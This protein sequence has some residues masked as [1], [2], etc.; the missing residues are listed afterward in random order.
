MRFVAT[1]VALLLLSAAWVYSGDVVVRYTRA[2]GGTN[3]FA[4]PV[5]ALTPRFGSMPVEQSS[6]TVTI[7]FDVQATT[8]PNLYVRF[9]H[10]DPLW[11]ATENSFINDVTLR[12]TLIDWRLAPSQSRYYTYRGILSIPNSQIQFRFPGNW[13]AII[14][15]IEDDRTLAEVRFFVVEP[16]VESRIVMMTDFYMPRRKVSAT[17]LSFETWVR[18]NP[19]IIMDNH[20]HTVVLYRNFRWFEPIAISS[21]SRFARAAPS[22]MRTGVS[23]MINVGK[24]FRADRLAAENEYRILDL[25]QA[26]LW[27]ATGQPVRLPLS[28]LPRNGDF[29]Q[30]ADDGAFSALTVSSIDD[31]YVPVEFIL[32]PFNVT[33]DRD[34]FVVGSFNNWRPTRE[35][36]MSFDS[37]QRLWRLRQWIRRGRHNYM[38]GTGHLNADDGTVLDLSFEDF[39]GNSSAVGHGFLALVYYR[40]PDFGGYDALV[41]LTTSN[42]FR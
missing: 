17:A 18:A 2:F 31:E 26:G 15:D 9:Q 7:E 23:G 25:S 34:V 41:G 27:P 24:I 20:L 39:E 29:I 28:D 4:P 19:G 5:A 42:I 22:G 36:E 12:T 1:V 16:L 33:V 6:Q 35:W 21:D 38:Y 32:D 3:Q 30:R 8:I 37:E 11:K 40:F 14:Y 13:K 10:C